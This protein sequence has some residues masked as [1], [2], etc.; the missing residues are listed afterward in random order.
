MERGLLL[1]AFL[2]GV[3]I[4]DGLFEVIDLFL[5]FHLISNLP[6]KFFLVSLTDLLSLVDLLSE[7][8]DLTLQIG[9]HPFKLRQF[10]PLLFELG[11]ILSP[12]SSHP[13]LFSLQL[14]GLLGLLL[15]FVLFA[16]QLPLQLHLMVDVQ[17]LHLE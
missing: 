3:L 6:R 8:H 11:L 10:L 14:L 17:F 7:T 12:Y 16:E 15:Q 9:H 13:L 2:A 5:E 4:S 1:E